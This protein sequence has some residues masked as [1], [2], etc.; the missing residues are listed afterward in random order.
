M[1]KVRRK[2]ITI[3]PKRLREAAG[4]A[5]DSEVKAKVL[6]SGIL[7][8]PFANEPVRVLEELPIERKRSSVTN[9]RRLRKSIDR[10]QREK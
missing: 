2:G 3:L 4:I 1:L 6:P 7:L 5:E 9:I 10:E 8:R